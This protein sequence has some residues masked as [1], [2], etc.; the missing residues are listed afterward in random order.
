MSRKKKKLSLHKPLRPCIPQIAR[1]L[2]HAAATA[3]VFFFLLCSAGRS[4]SLLILFAAGCFLADL[5]RRARCCG[6]IQAC[7]NLIAFT[8]GG[9]R[10]PGALIGVGLLRGPAYRKRS[11]VIFFL[12]R[13][14]CSKDD[15]LMWRFLVTTRLY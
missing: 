11:F 5:S 7:L 8:P 3:F 14:F 6:G 1:I 4:I 10:I 12:L 2:F 15:V 9:I 13:S